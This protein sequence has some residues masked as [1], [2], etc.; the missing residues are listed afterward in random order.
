M[1]PLERTETKE[2][3][4]NNSKGRGGGGSDTVGDYGRET[5]RVARQASLGLACVFERV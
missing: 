2:E 5:E 4:G 3:E 1:H